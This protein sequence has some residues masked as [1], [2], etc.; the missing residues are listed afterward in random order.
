M[1]QLSSQRT[2]NDAHATFRSLQ[3]KFPNELGNRQ[4]IIRRADLGSKGIVY[5]TNVGPF[6]TAQE[7]QPV[8]R[9]LQGSRRPVHRPP[10]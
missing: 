4:V 2:E 3:A 10:H 1:V 6:A 8:L 7:A 9:E 5:R